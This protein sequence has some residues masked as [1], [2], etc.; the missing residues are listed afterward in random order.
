MVTFHHEAAGG[1]RFF[2]ILQWLARDPDRHY[3]ALEFLYVLMSLGI[4]GHYRL[5]DSGL[6][7]HEY[8]R[9]RLYWLLRNRCPATDSM[10]LSD[11]P[12]PV[13]PGK[14][15]SS[16][17]NT[18]LAIAGIG[19]ALLS[20][21]VYWTGASGLRQQ[22][23]ALIAANARIQLLPDWTQLLLAAPASGQA[24]LDHTLETLLAPEIAKQLIALEISHQQTVIIFSG[25][26]LFDSGSS[27]IHATLE[28]LLL[29]IGQALKQVPGSIMVTGYTDNQPSVRG[30]P[31]NVQLS[32]SRANTVARL[33]MAVTGQPARYLVTGRGDS[34]PLVANDSPAHRARNRRVSIT[35]NT[36]NDNATSG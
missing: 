4:H 21:P 31:N 14:R 5:K 30:M 19:L 20:G 7:Q 35:V 2:R 15:R 28:P 29:Q 13:M 22:S 25:D 12:P 16:S 24:T 18:W 8:L 27:Q 3:Q 9:E 26:G 23:Q 11:C 32:R 36:R 6:N 1:E 34:D 33:L 17:P 10:L